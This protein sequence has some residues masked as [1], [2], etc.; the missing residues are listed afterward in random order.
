MIHD[1]ATAP[2]TP[3]EVPIRQRAP[4]VPAQKLSKRFVLGVVLALAV[5]SSIWRMMT[6][7]QVLVVESISP[8]VEARQEYLQAADSEEGLLSGPEP[9][10]EVT[11]VMVADSAPKEFELKVHAKQGVTEDED[12]GFYD[13]LQASAWSVPVQ[14]GIYLTAEDRQR[15]SYTYMLQAASLKSRSEAVSLVATLQKKGLAASYTVSGGGVGEVTWYRVNVG[16]FNNVSV[17]N[18]AKDV[19]VSM[20]MMPL[21]RR[22][23]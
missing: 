1:F 23:Q 19:L 3:R 7:E 9:V 15:A 22:I 20:R 11:E 13:T 10:V 18:K 12:Y 16:P 5:V 8:T 4:D 17:M 21:K 6:S 2:R 14:R